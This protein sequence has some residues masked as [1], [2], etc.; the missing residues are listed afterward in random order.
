[1]NF[2][3]LNQQGILIAGSLLLGLAGCAAIPDEH[4]QLAQRDAKTVTVTSNLKLASEGWPEARWW[5]S[6][7]DQQLNALMERA[8]KGAPSLDTA[9][10]RLQ[11]A[12][13]GIL[14]AQASTGPSLVADG[15]VSEE[16]ETQNGFI[17]PPYAGSWITNSRLALDFRYDFDWWGKHKDEVAIAAGQ[18]NVSRAQRATAETVLTTGIAKSYFLYQ[19]AVARL[20]L[21]QNL[22]ELRQRLLHL[23]QLRV[24]H[25][26]DPISNQRQAE[27]DL[28]NLRLTIADLQTQAQLE[29]N[30]LQALLGDQQP[31]QLT[32]SELPVDATKVPARLGLDL[33]ARRPDL[34]AARWQVESSKSAEEYAKAS[35]YPDFNLTAFAGLSSIRLYDL[36]NTKSEI[37]G[38]A[39]AFSLPIFDSGRLKAQL[40]VV[41]DYKQWQVAEYNQTLVNALKDVTDQ[42]ARLQGLEQQQNALDAAMDSSRHV[43]A[44]ALSRARQGIGDDFAVL[45][46]EVPLINQQDSA[47]QLASRRLLTQIDL[48]HALGGGY[49]ATET[50]QSQK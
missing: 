22:T 48:I 7:H 25:G 15:N 43:H 42:I 45:Q 35:F 14:Q 30:Q 26:L 27:G 36:L 5:E 49:H 19:T 50:A 3:C 13:S 32:A 41:R 47:A 34:Q 44:A 46:T 17:P 39:P 16:L 4:A 38:I 6:Y 24:S 8:L 20:Q 9:N 1:M 12:M 33:L 31:L 23:N 28:A 18:A 11:L 21:A 10:T 37:A 2:S 29:R 40:Q